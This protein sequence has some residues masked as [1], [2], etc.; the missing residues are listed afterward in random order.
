MSTVVLIPDST[1]KA[2]GHA[3]GFP[4][5]GILGNLPKKDAERL[6]ALRTSVAKAAN[7]PIGSDLD[8]SSRGEV[9]VM[10]AHL[11]FQGNM[12][13]H[14]P[15]EAWE[16]RKGDVDVIIV[17]ALYGLSRFRDPI[18]PYKF[19]MAENLP[20]LG[21]LNRW[22]RGNGL[23]SLLASAIHALETDRVVA[24]LSLEYRKAVDGYRAGLD[25]AVEAIAFPGMGRASQPRRGEVVADVLRGTR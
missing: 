21:V 1:R 2:P 10:P 5:P 4:R 3:P 18:R 19:S 23:P 16:N 20:G 11:R 25:V 12:Y 8:P 7:L 17:S 6:A 14:I 15:H 22:W 13:R 24:L 9:E